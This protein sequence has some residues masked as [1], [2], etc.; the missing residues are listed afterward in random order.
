MAST[1]NFRRIDID[2]YD[3]DRVLASSL[4]HPDPRQPAQA[5][6]DAQSKDRSVKGL[7]Q[8]GDVAAALKDAL[9]DGEW[10]Y[11]EDSVPEIKQAK[12][13]ALS[14]V[15]S[16]LNSTR[17]TDI[18]ALVQQLEPSEQVTLMKYL[19]KAMENLGDTSGNVVLGWHE[20]LTEVAGIGCI[21]RVMSDRRRV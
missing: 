13:T 8:R 5:L 1:A 16:I 10:P 2:Q 15:L 7:L 17:S 12:A 9:R 11:G 6:A 18:P 20:K 3:E 19:Y 21:V 14:T 4:Y